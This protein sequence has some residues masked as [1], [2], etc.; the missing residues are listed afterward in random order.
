MRRI[1]YGGTDLSDAVDDWQ[2]SQSHSTEEVEYLGDNH[3]RGHH[4]GTALHVGSQVL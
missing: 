2:V 3:V 1:E 4:V